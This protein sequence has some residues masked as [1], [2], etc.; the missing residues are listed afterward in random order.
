MSD[1]DL[2][3]ARRC[4]DAHNLHLHAEKTDAIG[5]YIAVRLSDGGSDGILYDKWVDAVRHQL[6][7][8]QCAYV[9]IQPDLMTVAEAAAFIRFNR[10]ARDAGLP[11][12]DPDVHREVIVPT[13]REDALS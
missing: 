5:R 6:H 4:A 7:R 9:C 12:A 11:M 3:T 13:R 1:V 10:A 8:D 2:D